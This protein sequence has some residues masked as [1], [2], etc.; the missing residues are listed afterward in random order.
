MTTVTTE[1][2]SSENN[3]VVKEVSSSPRPSGAWRRRLPLLPALIFAI[4]TTQIP[5]LLSIYF[6]FTEW[7][8]NERLT[9]PRTFVWF[10]NYRDL[11]SELLFI[12]DSAGLFRGAVW[13][14]IL[15]T[16]LSVFLSIAFGLGMAMLLDRKF[17]GQGLLRTLLITPFV[18]TPIVAASIWGQQMFNTNFGIINWF[19]GGIGV[20]AINF[21]SRFPLASV[22]TV[23]V[24][25]WTPFMMLILLA[26][27]QS[28]DSSVLEAARVDGA[29]KSSIFRQITIPHLRRYMELGALL[30][31]VYISQTFDQIERLTGGAGG[32]E[33]VVFRVSQQSIGGGW[34]F[35]LASAQSVLTV[36]GSI[37]F[38]TI[39]LRF[40]NNLIE[41]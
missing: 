30:G 4:I 8:F 15:M 19:L 26:G 18:V 31:V 32:S 24:W 25:Q 34:R 10:D 41:D 7:R 11:L 16:V 20:D 27:L 23:V 38:I 17:V 9:N 1:Q 37:V 39:G 13:F 12:G 2:N 36:I 33:T 3:A 35:G 22:V 40:L 21:P 14:T 5:F 28:Q 29:K 6:S